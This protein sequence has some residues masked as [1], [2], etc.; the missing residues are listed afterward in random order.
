MFNFKMDLDSYFKCLH[1]IELLLFISVT[2]IYNIYLSYIPILLGIKIF[3]IFKYEESISL[4][5]IIL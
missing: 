2:I 5:S 1:V 4:I 3:N